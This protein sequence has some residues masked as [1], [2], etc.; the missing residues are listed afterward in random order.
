[1]LKQNREVK[2]CQLWSKFLQS[3]LPISFGV[4]WSR[5][6][7]PHQIPTPIPFLISSSIT[8]SLSP[9][10]PP[11]T[12]ASL[13]PEHTTFPPQNLCIS[14]ALPWGMS[15][16]I[17]RLSCSSCSDRPAFPA[18]TPTPHPV[19][20]F[21]I[22]RTPKLLYHLLASYVSMSISCPPKWKPHMGRGLY[23]FH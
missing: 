22:A 7:S 20:S 14:C 19:S 11:V 13:F 15:P 5:V 3:Y 4:V 10:L 16:V 18:R 9:S 23:L 21:S 8:S 17:V 2:S 1:M 6:L 12:L